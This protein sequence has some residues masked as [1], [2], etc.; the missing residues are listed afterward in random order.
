VLCADKFLD[1][2]LVTP[3]FQIK[4][5]K[6]IG[7]DLGHSIDLNTVP[8]QWFKAGRR[9]QLGPELVLATG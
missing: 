4:A 8:E 1:P 9:G 6:R 3:R 5:A 7:H 2:G